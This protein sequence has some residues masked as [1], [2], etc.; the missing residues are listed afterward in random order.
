ME[1]EPTDKQ[2]TAAEAIRAAIV[3]D[4]EAA[5]AADQADS[6]TTSGEA[7]WEQEGY[8]NGLRAAIG[9][10]REAS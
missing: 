10:A 3:A 7:I 6:D 8:R 1:R 4:I 9:I 2:I 5:L